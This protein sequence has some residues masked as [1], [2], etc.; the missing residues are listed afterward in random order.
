MILFSPEEVPPW[1]LF[2]GEGGGGVAIWYYFPLGK[3]CHGL[4]S[5]GRF[6]IWYSFRGNFV[7]WHN[8]PGKFLGGEIPM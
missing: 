5:G 1:D 8:F 2:R 6:A 4:S 7:L 3:F